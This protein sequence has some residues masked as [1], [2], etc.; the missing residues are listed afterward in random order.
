MKLPFRKPPKKS[1]ADIARD[2]TAAMEQ[3]YV[4]KFI[5]HLDKKVAD[6]ISSGRTN[7][8]MSTHDGD[9]RV[10]ITM[11]HKLIEAAENEGFKV[12]ENDRLGLNFLV[13]WPRND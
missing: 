7:V 2:H 1:R 12:T 3:S 10:P 4:D 5:E 13:S 6:A 9:F 11:R 8:I